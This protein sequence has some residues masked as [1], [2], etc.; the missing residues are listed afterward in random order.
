M[1]SA[2]VCTVCVWAREFYCAKLR[3]R[4]LDSGDLLP[5]VGRSK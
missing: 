3:K 4:T 5:L 1:L 2:D